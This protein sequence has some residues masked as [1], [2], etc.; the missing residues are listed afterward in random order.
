MTD[1]REHPAASAVF[2]TTKTSTSLS[3]LSRAQT[4]GEYEFWNVGEE[5]TEV[6][7]FRAQGNKI[8]RLVVVVVPGNPGVIDYYE[9]FLNVIYE[10]CNEMVDIIG[11]QHLGHSSAV[12]HDRNFSVKDQVNHKIALLDLITEKYGKDMKIVLMGHSFGAW[13]S[14][15]ML[16]ARPDANMVKIFALFPTLHSIAATPKGRR[17]SYLTLP[18]V[19]SIPPLFVSFLRTLTYFTP[20]LFPRLISTFSGQ[21]GTDLTITCGKLLHYRTVL[22]TLYLA[23]H[24]MREIKDLDEETVEKNI[25]KF[26]FYYGTKDEWCPVWH[27]EQMSAK[28]PKAEIHL[29]RDELP[30]AFVLG[31]SDIMGRKV[32]Q[33]LR[34]V[35]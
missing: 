13:V 7:L 25:E 14:V 31:Y 18:V 26:V 17:I 2:P 33:W 12:D 16:K 6:L 4:A 11:V 28:F 21:T 29:C 34:N 5:E 30:H 10:C 15:Q 35:L 20:K 22:N 8:P 1:I 24:E 27:W 32:A 23:S 19:R 9:T 3:S